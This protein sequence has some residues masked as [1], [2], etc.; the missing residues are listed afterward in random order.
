MY[1]RYERYKISVSGIAP[2]DVPGIE[3]INLTHLVTEVS[4]HP[5]CLFA[6]LCISQFCLFLF[7]SQHIHYSTKMKEILEIINLAKP[8]YEAALEPTIT[9]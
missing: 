2:V 5:S 9:I 7:G 3:N 4:P 1:C 6:L 8:K